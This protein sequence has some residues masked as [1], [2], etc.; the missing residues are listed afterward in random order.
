MNPS[1][2]D[3]K[4]ETLTF[5]INEEEQQSIVTTYPA[6]CL[7]GLLATVSAWQRDEVERQLKKYSPATIWLHGG[8]VDVSDEFITTP[9]ELTETKS[10]W[11]VLPF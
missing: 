6:D 9:M 5:F 7:T 8:F 1:K 11:E 4:K 10:F 2:F 3:K